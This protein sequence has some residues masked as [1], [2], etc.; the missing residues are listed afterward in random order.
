[1]AVAAQKR[2]G[3]KIIH[4]SII[5]MAESVSDL[6]ELAVLLKEPSGSIDRARHRGGESRSAVRDDRRPAAPVRGHHGGGVREPSPQAKI[7]ASRGNTQ[8]VMLGYSD[9]NKDGGF[10]TSGWELYK[11]EIAL[12][13]TFKEGRHRHAPVPRSRRLGRAR[14]RALLRRDPRAARRRRRRTDPHH[15][16]GRD[17]LVEIRA[18]T[19]PAGATSTI[20]VAATLDASLIDSKLP[21]P[22]LQV[23]RQTMGELSGSRLQAAYRKLVYETEGLRRLISG[24]RPSSTR[25]RR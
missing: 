13:E 24:T 20:I 7:V 17:H 8:E 9:S 21:P 25:S 19:T 1:M 14:R 6:L 2:Y 3:H 15:R 23:F 12:V 18:R 11:A 16:A 22:P 5:S 4:T 10:V